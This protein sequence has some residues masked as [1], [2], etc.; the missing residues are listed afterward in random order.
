MLRMSHLFP[1]SQDFGDTDL[2]H[3]FMQFGNIISAKVFIDKATQQSKCFGEGERK[4]GREGGREGGVEGGVREGG[5]EG[6]VREGGKE[7]GGRRE[8]GGREVGGKRDG[9]GREGVREEGG[10]K[11]GEG[12]REGGKEGRSICSQLNN[13]PKSMFLLSGCY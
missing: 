5:V 1:T 12:R 2:F 6:G 3:L 11:E 9:G 8:G 4:G 7:E 13:N 10:R